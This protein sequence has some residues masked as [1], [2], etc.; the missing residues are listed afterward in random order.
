MSSA[1]GETLRYGYIYPSHDPYGGPIT[2]DSQSPPI[3]NTPPAPISSLLDKAI[4]AA[5]ERVVDADK[6]KKKYTNYTRMNGL[7]RI[8]PTKKQY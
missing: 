2:V 6:V 7:H 8:M 5:N 1:Y 3:R 4:N